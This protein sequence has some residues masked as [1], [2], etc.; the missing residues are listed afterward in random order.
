MAGGSTITV[1]ASFVNLL[2]EMVVTQLVDCAIEISDSGRAH[3]EGLEECL[4]EPFE[5]YCAL[6]RCV[7]CLR[8]VPAV[9]VQIALPAHRW[10]LIEALRHGLDFEQ[11]MAEQGDPADPQGA[12]QRR[13]A[14]RRVRQIE[15]FLAT[16]GLEDVPRRDL[17]VQA[18]L[19]RHGERQLTHEEVERHFGH[20]PTDGEG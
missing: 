11:W 6:L 17:S 9:A 15:R 12:K 1:P 8:T 4:L 19:T 13:R 18:M 16:A 2:R 5:R 10:A 20:I 3:P 14:Q 7:G